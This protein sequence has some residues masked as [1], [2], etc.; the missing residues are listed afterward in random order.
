[1]NS[2][3][4]MIAEA[5]TRNTYWEERAIIE[6]T[7]EICRLMEEQGVSRAE[8]ARRLGKSQAWVT[9]LLGGSNNFTLE[10]MVR[11]SRTMGGELRV[12]IQPE[13]AQSVWYEFWEKTPTDKPQADAPEIPFEEYQSLRELHTHA[14]VGF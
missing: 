14:V 2:F 6:F 11:V 9:K 13:G 10:T 7:A 5:Q 3:E 12:H 4:T 1:M 8:L